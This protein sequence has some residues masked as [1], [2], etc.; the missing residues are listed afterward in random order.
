MSRTG[1]ARGEKV[2]GGGGTMQ[3]FGEG[4]HIKGVEWRG[5]ESNPSPPLNSRG[6]GAAGSLSLGTDLETT[7]DPFRPLTAPYFAISKFTAPS[8]HRSSRTAPSKC[9]FSMKIFVCLI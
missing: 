7:A 6:E 2:Q 9:H 8:F 4:T 5:E 3:D 1:A